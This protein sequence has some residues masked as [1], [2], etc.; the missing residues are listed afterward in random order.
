LDYSI[1]NLLNKLFIFNKEEKSEFRFY[2]YNNVLNKINNIVIN[3]DMLYLDMVKKEFYN[4]NRDVIL[5][6]IDE[7][8][9][10][11]TYSLTN[12]YK[13]NNNINNDFSFNFRI[14]KKKKE[15]RN[16]NIDI[17]DINI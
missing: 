10:I 11:N 16:K 2:S 13:F 3:S 14:Y 7:E 9:P 6:K 12:T 17:L 8:R 1:L 5:S 4:I 15:N